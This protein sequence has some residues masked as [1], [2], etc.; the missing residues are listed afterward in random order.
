[1]KLRWGRKVILACKIFCISEGS[2]GNKELGGGIEGWERVMQLKEI[3]LR[4]LVRE[5]KGEY[6]AWGAFAKF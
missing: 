3:G 2:K 1:M 6:C 4:K 5:V